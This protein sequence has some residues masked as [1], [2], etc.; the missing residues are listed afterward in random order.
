MFSFFGIKKNT[1]KAS[2]F[3]DFCRFEI[4]Y[5]EVEALDWSVICSTLQ[6]IRDSCLRPAAELVLAPTDSEALY[7]FSLPMSSKEF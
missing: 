5:V 1:M 4:S 7:V 2:D 3:S 6:P